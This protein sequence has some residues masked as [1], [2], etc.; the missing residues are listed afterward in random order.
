MQ[1]SIS[2]TFD[3]RDKVR[4]SSTRLFNLETEQLA[5]LQCNCLYSMPKRFLVL[6]LQKL[7]KLLTYLEIRFH[8]LIYLSPIFKFSPNKSVQV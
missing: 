8:L 5:S 3:Q 2:D 1:P 4:S 7:Q 6:T